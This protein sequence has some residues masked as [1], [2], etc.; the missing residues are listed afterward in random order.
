MALELKARLEKDGLLNPQEG[1]GRLDIYTTGDPTEYGRRAV[2]VGLGEADSVN[3][4]P[5][6]EL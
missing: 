2:Q 1:P 5:P 4:Y 6:M 3:F